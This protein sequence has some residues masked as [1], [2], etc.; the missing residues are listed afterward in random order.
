M[1]ILQLQGFCQTRYDRLN[2]CIISVVLTQRSRNNRRR[3]KT[4]PTVEQARAFCECAKHGNY[5]LAA[6][7]MGHD[8]RVAIIRLV[9]RFADALG[10]GKLV[11][12][13]SRGNVSVT[14]EGEAALPIA[15]RFVNAADAL[16]VRSRPI[17]FSAYPGVTIQVLR[18][19]P[20]LLSHRPPVA[21]TGISEQSRRDGGRALVSGLIAN[22]LDLVVAPEGLTGEEIVGDLLYGWSLRVLSAGTDERTELLRECEF[23]TPD[24]LLGFS[25]GAAPVGHRSRLMLDSL[26]AKHGVALDFALESASQEL[27]REFVK[28]NPSHV[29]VLPD[30]AFG[31]LNPELGP[32]LT[33]SDGEPWGSAY[34]LYRRAPSAVRDEHDEEVE[35]LAQLLIEYV[36]PEAHQMGPGTVGGRS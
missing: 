36:L 32:L 7:A 26:C 16:V 12:A 15:R 5:G 4:A 6:E 8:D 33:T 10:Q 30:D 35:R 25:V 24:D 28:V 17:R 18:S 20:Q 23:V 1:Y 14:P 11:R 21:L 27:L 19:Y 13:D 3:R 31:E 29:A 2:L 34:F 22:E 9:S